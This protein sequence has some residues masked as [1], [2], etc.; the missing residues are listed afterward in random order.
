MK[1]LGIRT[2]NLSSSWAAMPAGEIRADPR[3]VPWWRFIWDFG[4]CLSPLAVEGCYRLL[5]SSHSQSHEYNLWDC[6][7]RELSVDLGR[8]VEHKGRNLPEPVPSECARN[9]K[10]V[11]T[12]YVWFTFSRLLN[13]TNFYMSIHLEKQRTGCPQTPCHVRSYT[14]AAWSCLELGASKQTLSAD[15]GM[16]CND[17]RA[18]CFLV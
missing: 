4:K 7:H 10:A 3:Q 12:G 18:A 2:K 9:W 1:Y 15:L 17:K 14:I 16:R 11:W 6:C 13:Q 5:L 8:D